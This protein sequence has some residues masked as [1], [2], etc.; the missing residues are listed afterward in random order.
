MTSLLS[1]I[2]GS[3]Q[4]DSTRIE[5][6][7]DLFSNPVPPPQP[8]STQTS[9]A[10]S[11][12]K[13]KKGSAEDAKVKEKEQ[14]QT[15]NNDDDE[16]GEQATTEADKD[17]VDDRTIFVGNL[18]ATATRKDLVRLFRSQGPIVSTRIRSVATL[19]FN[20]DDDDDTKKKDVIKLPPHLA[21]RQNVVR[22]I[23]VNQKKVDTTAKAT[24]QGYVVFANVES[25][26]KALT[27][28]N[29]PFRSKDD[30]NDE[31]EGGAADS[32]TG[33]R[34]LRV[35]RVNKEYDARRSIKLMKNHFVP[36]S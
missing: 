29:T 30:D 35:D 36:V 32:T 20:D 7:A 28:N 23:L 16:G 2:F 11:N 22:K 13:R 26:E 9:N 19:K 31:K 18:P 1:S 10:S 25:V 5:E 34:L 3:G 33:R 12:K 6:T 17:N 4:K 15:I 14:Q 21:G 24:V 8:V 27:M